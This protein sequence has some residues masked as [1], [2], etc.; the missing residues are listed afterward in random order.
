M[1]RTSSNPNAPPA[2]SYGG[3]GGA[4]GSQPPKKARFQEDFD[5]FMP[6]DDYDGAEGQYERVEGADVE[7]SEM[8]SGRWIRPRS[9]VHDP[10]TQPLIFQWLDIDMI[11][12][13]PLTRNPAGGDVVGSIDAIVPIVRLYGVTQEGESVMAC[14]HGVTPYFYASFS[15]FNDLNDFNLGLIRAA[16]DS[17]VSSIDN[18]VFSTSDVR[19]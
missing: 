17:R 9:A 3:G 7:D 11:S 19:H 2:K 16:M 4:G 13:A 1:K 5:D 18:F 14:I 10:T 6:E 8:Q 12:G 15:G